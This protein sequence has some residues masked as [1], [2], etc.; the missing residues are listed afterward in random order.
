MKSAVCFGLIVAVGW[1]GWSHSCFA[2]DN[3]SRAA[4]R[5]LVNQGAEE[6]NA[7]RYEA[8]LKKFAEALQVAKVP[9]VA[10]WA[11]EANEKLDRL[12]AAAELYEQALLM[13]PNDLWV[14]SVQEDAQAKARE[15]LDQL[16]PRIPTLKVEV[17]GANGADLEVT[18]DSIQVPNSLLAEP[19][20]L[21][22]G[23][24]TITARQANKT[25]TQSVALM[26]A[27]KQ[28]VSLQLTAPENPQP[29]LGSSS[30]LSSGSATD[31]ASQGSS[32]RWQRTAGWVSVGVGAAG[33]AFGATTGVVV[34]LKRSSLHNDGCTANTCL[35][36]TYKSRV[37]SYNT[38]RT[39]STVG[40]VVG[41]VATVAGVTFL[42]TS[43]TQESS[44]KVGLLV[45]P[46]GMHIAGDF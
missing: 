35:G 1:L 25:A 2:I 14:G 33:I 17:V 32:P 13:Q 37:D 41:G 23:T 38:L 30:G 21:D 27:Q 6:Y 18:I 15:A 7:G 45:S 46:T 4:A 3:S 16:R 42:L 20:P 8:A 5:T 28:V 11:A 40:F 26:E 44:V 19:R 22:P 10:V 36:P 34:G 9:T 31:K 24:H 12:V 39:L 29:V 43:P